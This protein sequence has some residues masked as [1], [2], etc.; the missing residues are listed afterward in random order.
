MIESRLHD[1]GSLVGQPAL[2]AALS[3]LAILAGGAIPSIPTRAVAH[4]LPINVGDWKRLA[5]CRLFGVEPDLANLR[6][7]FSHW[8]HRRASLAPED[9]T[10]SAFGGRGCPPHLQ[11]WARDIQESGSAQM[12]RRRMSNSDFASDDEVDPRTWLMWGMAEASV[13]QE[14]VSELPL[15]LQVEQEQLFL[16]YDRIRAESELRSAIVVPL[17]VLTA[18]LS[19]VSVIWLVALLLPLWLLRQAVQSCVEAE[20]LLLSAVMHDVI[21]SSTVEFLNSLGP[22]AVTGGVVA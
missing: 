2:F 12:G 3:L 19:S 9:L 11:V 4:R 7:D 16:E 8:L 21:P 14:L 10:W 13:E 18:L 22:E 20:Q 17:V 1:L 15:K 6:G 5:V